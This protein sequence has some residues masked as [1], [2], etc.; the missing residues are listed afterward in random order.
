MNIKNLER[1]YLGIQSRLEDLKQTAV[2]LEV[3]NEAKQAKAEE[4]KKSLIE[5]GVDVDRLDEE[6]SRIVEEMGQILE[7]GLRLVQEFSD[8]LSQAEQEDLEETEAIEEEESEATSLDI[9]DL[10][11]D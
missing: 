11:L 10:D 3:E 4:L 2:R 8:S 1:E 5:A 7:D 6:K 9:S